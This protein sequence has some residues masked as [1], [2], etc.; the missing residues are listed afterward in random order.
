MVC[1]KCGNSTSEKKPAF[2][3]FCGKKF[4]APKMGMRMYEWLKFAPESEVLDFASQ[5]PLLASD[6]V[7][8]YLYR[9]VPSVEVFGIKMIFRHS[10]V[11]GEKRRSYRIFASEAEKSRLWVLDNFSNVRDIRFLVCPYTLRGQDDPDD[12]GD[13]WF[14]NR[15]DAERALEEAL[16]KC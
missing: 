1:S 13:F 12:A 10:E 9:R 16:K 11:R 3:P 5:L 7:V 2:C 14:W 15:E 6:E 8:K 4:S